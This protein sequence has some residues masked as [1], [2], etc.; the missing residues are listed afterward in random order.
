MTDRHYVDDPR[1][2]RRRNLRIV[3]AIVASV[4]LFVAVLWFSVSALTRP[5]VD[6]GDNFMAALKQG[7]FPRAYA[8]ATPELQRELG[9]PD[10]F[11]GL[12]GRGRPADWGWSSRSIRN[13]TGR[14]SGAYTALDG[15]RGRAELVLRKV[16]GAWRITAFRFSP[17]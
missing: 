2:R 12:A 14:V 6:A 15:R 13:S 11:A 10:D 3:L 7:D 5:V 16:D 8:L 17:E 4:A 1:L 9:S